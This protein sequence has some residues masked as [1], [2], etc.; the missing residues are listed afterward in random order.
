M[1]IVLRSS[2]SIPTGG[3]AKRDKRLAVPSRI[4]KAQNGIAL[5]SALLILVMLTLLAL[6]MFRGFG[7]EQKIAGNVREK[8]R[9]FQAA[10]N[11]LQFGE[12]WLL[13]QGAQAPTDA[14]IQVDCANTSPVTFSST[15][16]LRVCFAELANPTDPQNWVGAGTYLPPSMTVASGGGAATD[17]NGNADINY[18]AV[19]LVYISRI[20]KNSKLGLCEYRVTGGGYGGSA[21]S[22]S[23]VQS[24]VG[25]PPSFC[26]ESN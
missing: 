6:A 17:G 16:D 8:E 21:N 12:T 3:A 1:H 23:V 20:G 7:L 24:V 11:A 26:T 14:T 15:A 25:M 2:I 4:V 10:E 5:I 19:P 13:A 18:A 22:V 9:A